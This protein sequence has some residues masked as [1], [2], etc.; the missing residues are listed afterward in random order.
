[1]PACSAFALEAARLLKARGAVSPAPAGKAQAEVEEGPEDGELPAAPAA[2][3]EQGSKKRKHSPIVWQEGG[4]R[5]GRF[6][7]LHI[8]LFAQLLPLYAASSCIC[9]CLCCWCLCL[10]KLQLNCNCTMECARINPVQE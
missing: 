4:K 9:L 10:A 5:A 2:V 1:M 6:H 8:T 7:V 3:Q